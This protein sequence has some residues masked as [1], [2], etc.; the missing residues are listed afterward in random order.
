MLKY[1]ILFLFAVHVFAD[2]PCCKEKERL[3]SYLDIAVDLISKAKN[4]IP[5]CQKNKECPEINAL[6][7]ADWYV[8]GY[9]K[10][11][12]YNVRP[13]NRL[14]PNKSLDV[15]CD[16]DTNGGGW[17]V[18]QRRGNFGRPDNYFY[19]G[20]SSYKD[21]FGDID[22]DFWLGN[23]NIFALTNQKLYSIRFDMQARNLEKAYAEFSDFWI[24][25]ESSKYMLHVSNYSGSAGDNLTYHNGRK[26]T[27]KDQNNDDN[28]K[29]NCAVKYTG[30]WWY[31]YCRFVDLNGMYNVQ[32]FGICW[33]GF[34][35]CD[36][37]SLI[38]TEMKIRPK[39]F[40]SKVLR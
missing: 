28:S 25:D 5:G 13:I 38:W 11:G 9:N 19:R 36:Q 21:G 16:M 12:V 1:G 7:C 35:K 14:M 2:A 37:P 4:S 24:D 3:T 34:R 6:D 30:A 26:F 15:F 17:T 8:R 23:D 22:K 33:Y 39:S 20:W 40:T 31:N 32:K 27:T 10:S 29:E 18:I